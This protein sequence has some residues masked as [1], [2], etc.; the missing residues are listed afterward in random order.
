M[1]LEAQDNPFPS[2]L[3]VETV[4]P[5]TPAAGTQ[6][7]FVDTDGLLKLIDDAA[8]VVT[9]PTSAS[10]VSSGTSFPGSPADNDLYYRT[11]L[12]ELY[13][14]EATG[15]KWLCATLH[16]LTWRTSVAFGTAGLT[17][18]TTVLAEALC[19]TGTVYLETLQCMPLV[20]TTNDGSKYWTVELSKMSVT[21]VA[22]QIGQASSI[23]NTAGSWIDES[24]A[25]G[26]IIDSAT[27]P[28]FRIGAT[29]VSTAGACYVIW[30]LLWR[31]I[32]DV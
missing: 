11:D 13:R 8:T 30:R 5:A 9:Y 22:T 28:V 29:K 27:N 25:L 17:A 2:L 32:T 7:L 4:D 21:N 1:A 6:R 19:P 14:Y 18:S 16:E 3:F 31:H 15:T 26:L 23:S 24:V 10:G 20:A 12:D